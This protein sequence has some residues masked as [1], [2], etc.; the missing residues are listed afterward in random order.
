MG[1]VLIKTFGLAVFYD[2]PLL[3]LMLWRLLNYL[4]VGGIE[5]FLLFW[6]LKHKAIRAFELK[7]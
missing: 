3:M 5:Y 7:K 6:I 1:S 4:I 2:M